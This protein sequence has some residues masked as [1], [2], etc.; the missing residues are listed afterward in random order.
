MEVPSWNQRNPL[1]VW[2]IACIA[3][4][5]I[6]DYVA[7]CKQCQNLHANT[8]LWRV[9]ST[10][11][12]SANVHW[13]RLMKQKGETHKNFKDVCHGAMKWLFRLKIRI[14]PFL[15]AQ[16]H[17]G[18][19]EKLSSRWHQLRSTIGGRK[20]SHSDDYQNETDKFDWSETLSYYFV[21]IYRAPGETRPV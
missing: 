8:R 16:N 13:I 19:H 15:G 9:Q 6:T 11:S 7:G 17:Y 10:L 12:V 20:V 5:S 3:L 4:G 14:K 21:T 1:K 2:K 18:F